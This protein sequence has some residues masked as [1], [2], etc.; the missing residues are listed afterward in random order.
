MAFVINGKNYE[1]GNDEWMFPAKTLDAAF[2]SQ[3]G[4]KKLT[5]T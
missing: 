4:I 1:L 3:G 5:F 2:L